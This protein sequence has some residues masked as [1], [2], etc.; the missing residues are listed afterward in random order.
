MDFKDQIKQLGDRVA[1]MKDKINTEEATKKAFMM[2]FIQVLGY[3]I[4]NPMEVVPEFVADL[5]IKKGEKLDY[6]IMKDEYPIILI[7][8]KHW[9]ADLDP[10]NSQL[11]RYFHTT[12]AKFGILTN[13]IFYRFYT[14][15]KEP[16]KM[17]EKP[18][19]EFRKNYI[20]TA[21]GW[22]QKQCRGRAGCSYTLRNYLL[23]F[24]RHL[25]CI[26]F[27]FTKTTL[28]NEFYFTCNN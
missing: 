19:F 18:F 14:D 6:A 17:D 21:K 20:T 16:N 10:H 24:H 4:L 11:F 27:Q 25:H 13:G 2:P 5:G 7:E 3:D 28:L 23:D 9:S 8:C 15:L 26:K 22:Q 12:K 1:K